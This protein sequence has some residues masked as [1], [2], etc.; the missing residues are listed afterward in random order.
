ME[1]DLQVVPVAEVEPIEPVET[2]PI[3]PVEQIDEGEV[4]DDGE[5]PIGS[6]SN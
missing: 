3:D 4:F 5:V 2:E 1:E 6:Q